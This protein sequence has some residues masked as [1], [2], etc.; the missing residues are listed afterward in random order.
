MKLTALILCAT[1][2]QAQEQSN[3]VVVMMDDMTYSDLDSMP[4]VQ[5]FLVDS[6]MVFDRMY[7]AN[8]LC[9]PNRAAF[10]TGKFPHNNGVLTNMAP[11][12]GFQRYIE[13]GLDTN[14]LPVQM[15]RLGYTT[16]IAGKL[17]NQF[18]V[19]AGYTFPGWDSV[20]V[21]DGR[22]FYYRIVDKQGRV[23]YYGSQEEEYEADVL[24]TKIVAWISEATG[25]KFCYYAPSAPH[26]VCVPPQRYAGRFDG[27]TAPRPPSFN[28]ADVS[29][30]P[31]YIQD[32]PLLGNGQQ[33]QVDEQYRGRLG[34]ILAVDDAIGD[35]V[36][37][38]RTTGQLENA[39]L[40]FT[41]DNGFELGE[42]RLTGKQTPY[43][44][45]VHVPLIIR[46][47]GVA[48]GVSDM[49]VSTVD[50]FPTIIELGASER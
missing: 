12:G 14:A 34:T 9:C 47:P 21:V 49:L 15:Q 29:D 38:L 4:N 13:L 6:G 10:L 36:E 5:K 27:V 44:E 1:L 45:A 40:I 17:L 37:A 46:G 25:P 7:V 23:V 8:S 31:A 28:E 24:A 19:D 43:D 48:T 18:E 30:K 41:S 16:M 42:H 32:L 35:I 2:A 22:Y 33:A 3:I 11:D 26:R 39:Y 50:L 20:Q